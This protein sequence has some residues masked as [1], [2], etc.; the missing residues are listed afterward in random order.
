MRPKGLA[1]EH[2][3]ADILLRYAMG[4]CPVNAGRPWTRQEMA[5]AIERG[6]HVSAMVPDAMDQLNSEVEDKVKKGQ[7]K[8]VLWDDIKHN[9]PRE[10]KVSPIAM[11]PHKS[12]KY[13]AIL[14]LSFE[15]RLKSGGV[16][17]SVNSST[18]KTAPHGAINQMGHSLMRIIHA[19]AEADRTYPDAKIF[20]AK[21]DIKDGFWRLVCEEGE[22]WNFAYV[23]PQEEGKPIKL[24]V[25]TALQMGWVESP[26]YFCAASETARDIA[27]RYAETPVGSH[28]A[29]KFSKYTEAH[30]D[31]Q[32]LPETGDDG[33]LRY[34]IEVYVDDYISI[35][36]ATSREQL[37]HVSRSVMRGVHDVFPEEEPDEEDPLSLKKLKKM[38][39]AWALV[40]SMLGFEFNG[41][42]KT[43]W[44]E[45]PKRDALLA[46]L[47][48]WLRNSSAK[49]AG[50]DFNEFISVL[51]KIRHA[52]ISIPAGKGLL[53]PCNAVLRWAPQTV[54]LHRNEHLRQ[55][56]VDIR[57]LLRESTVRPTKCTE[58]VSDWPDFIGIKDASGHGVGGIIVGEKMGCP[59]TVFRLKWPEYISNDI[60]TAENP[61]G[62]LTNS[63]LEL[64]GLL[65]L[66]L[67]MEDVCKPPPACHVALFSD[68]QPT[69]HWV[70]RL[71]SKS[72]A[73]AGQLLRAL[74]LRLKL[75]AASPLTP[76]H[77]RG[78]ENAI[79]DIPS[80]SF[81]SNPAYFCE[82]D[83]DLKPLFDSK[84]PLPNQNSWTVYQP[85]LR[86]SMRVISVLRMTTTSADEW[87]RLPR[88]G[89]H[90]GE[91]G[92]DMS[93]L[94]EWT[95]SFRKPDTTTASDASPVSGHESEQVTLVEANKCKLRRSL[96][97]SRPLGRRSLWPGE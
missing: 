71:A 37:D 46:T 84:F 31:Y 89:K 14:D 78:I 77:I 62:R 33:N 68:N 60:N 3:A 76:Q 16:I 12:R 50:I 6:P 19:F 45:G 7:V 35:A 73:V 2:P 10:L 27:T 54:Y 93:N 15:C 75:K 8:L 81:G 63:D 96:A 59:P 88:I 65:L 95:L 92:P 52:F 64:A 94:W 83:A 86:I 20:S 29:H 74:A 44:L 85:S 34:L 72:S 57:A 32:A 42:D 55:A 66:W 9:P 25:P 80:R 51:S 56:I 38:E 49:R 40:K 30:S 13:R 23:L 47:H 82:T 4:G 91:I 69:V 1:L 79:T 67:V 43:L 87:R 39:G 22:E 18:T 41:D 24:V 90:I 70:E 58:L 36:M 11:I 5:A 48:T 26:P 17:P 61:R 28:S 97:R 53:S 21:W